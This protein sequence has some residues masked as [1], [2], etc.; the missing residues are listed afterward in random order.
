M[1]V[2]KLSWRVSA[3]VPKHFAASSHYTFASCK[4]SC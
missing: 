1:R 4:S 3:E 2:I